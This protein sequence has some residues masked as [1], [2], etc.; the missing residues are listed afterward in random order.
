MEAKEEK[1]IKK[2]KPTKVMNYMN[3]MIIVDMNEKKKVEQ[4]RQ[5]YLQGE[6]YPSTCSWIYK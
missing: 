2:K 1:T 6:T 3:R 4:L 5:S